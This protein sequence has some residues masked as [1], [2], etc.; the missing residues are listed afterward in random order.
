[1]PIF[2]A[3]WNPSGF[4]PRVQLGKEKRKRLK[5]LTLRKDAQHPKRGKENITKQHPLPGS[6]VHMEPYKAPL[7]SVRGA[8]SRDQNLT[9]GGG[10]VLA[11]KLHVLL[12][13]P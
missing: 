8:A 13:A 12:L 9:Y 3:S 11:Q 2:K 6:A 7:P 5:Y 1:L 10:R 4:A